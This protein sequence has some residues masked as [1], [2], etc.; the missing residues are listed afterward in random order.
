MVSFEKVYYKTFASLETNRDLFM[1]NLYVPTYDFLSFTRVLGAQFSVA[2][3]GKL[4]HH[5]L[6]S[7][8][9]S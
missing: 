9:Q 5:L 6:N 7:G 4:F 2:A 3:S 8:T 1:N